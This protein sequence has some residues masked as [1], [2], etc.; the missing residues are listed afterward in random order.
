MSRPAQARL[1]GVAVFA[2]EALVVGRQLPDVDAYKFGVALP[3]AAG[4]DTTS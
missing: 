4:T 3:W 2:Q 1:I